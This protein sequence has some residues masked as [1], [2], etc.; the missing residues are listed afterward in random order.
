[1][2]EPVLFEI[3][4][5]LESRNFNLGDIAVLAQKNKYL[6]DISGRLISKGY[7]VVAQSSLD[8]RQRTV[9]K[10]VGLFLSFLNSPQDDFNFGC[11]LLGD[12]F[13]AAMPSDN[14][15]KCSRNELEHFL[16][17]VKSLAG[18]N[19]PLYIIFRESF[20]SLWNIY[21]EEIFHKS[22]FLSLYETVLLI[23]KI[24]KIPE[25]FEEESAYLAHF[26]DII[27]SVEKNGSGNLNDI[28]EPIYSEND[29]SRDIFSIELPEVKNA[30]TLLTVHKAKGLQWGA[31]INI[32]FAEENYALRQLSADDGKNL[33]ALKS[34]PSSGRILAGRNKNDFAVKNLELDL[35]PELERGNKSNGGLDLLYITKNI[36]SRFPDLENIYNESVREENISDLNNFYVALTR[37]KHEMYNL[38]ISKGECSLPPSSGGNKKY[39]TKIVPTHGYCGGDSDAKDCGGGFVKLDCGY[40]DT[41]F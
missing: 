24:F 17:T 7:P 9:I 18:T 37:A 29:G 26:L 36:S 20:N 10:E 30:I 27:L 19:K 22:G 34:S 35:D 12:I 8:I 13:G 23:Y 41:G 15:A 39:I 14:S 40:R 3:I 38:I 25:N 28:L 21:F 2:L 31:V 5:D 33:E 4:K 11:F 32:F 6:N 1:M 16:F